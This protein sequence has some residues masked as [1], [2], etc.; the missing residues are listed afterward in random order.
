MKTAR[1]LSLLY[2]YDS[3]T[4]VPGTMLQPE[5]MQLNEKLMKLQWIPPNER[6]GYLNYYQLRKVLRSKES[7]TIQIYR[8]NGNVNSC[9]L[10]GIV[11]Q[12]DEIEFTIRA[13]NIEDAN[14]VLIQGSNVNNNSVD[15]FLIEETI[16]DEHKEFH[17]EWSSSCFYICHFENSWAFVGIGM[18][19]VFICMLLIL[20]YRLYIK[21]KLM[22]DI[23]VIL[24]NGFNRELKSIDAGTKNLDLIQNLH[25]IT[26]ECEADAPMLPTVEEKEYKVIKM[27]DIVLSNVPQ[28]KNEDQVSE[29]ISVNEKLLPFICDPRTDK[30]FYQMPIAVDTPKHKP[31]TLSPINTSYTKFIVQDASPSTFVNYNNGYTKMN[32]PTRT[33]TESNTSIEGYCD[34]SGKSTSPTSPPP[35]K[36]SN[37]Q[38]HDI[39]SFLNAAELNNNGYIGKRTSLGDSNLSQKVPPVARNN[40]DYTGIQLN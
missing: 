29:Q 19:G 18:L 5:I 8:L 4:L 36:M 30:I 12:R 33:R 20:F 16:V 39:K 23:K 24:P 37:Y 31:V 15:C 25:T 40:S 7:N 9:I 2:S 35:I 6:S 14:D 1:L 11:C 10:S 38:M 28:E 27:N 3:F 22:R 17:G 21:Y 13:I 32:P 34:M 26:E